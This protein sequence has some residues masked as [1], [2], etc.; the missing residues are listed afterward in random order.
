MNMLTK[1][2]LLVLFFS[3]G[4]DVNQVLVVQVP[5]HIWG[6]GSEHL[7]HLRQRQ[8]KAHVAMIHQGLFLYEQASDHVDDHP[9]GIHLSLLFGP[10]HTQINLT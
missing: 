9:D 1:S 8:H 3:V 6:E 7:L 5:C 10:T 4:D 2:L